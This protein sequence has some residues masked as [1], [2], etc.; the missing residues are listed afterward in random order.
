MVT[1]G[2]VTGELLRE[3]RCAAGIGLRRMAAQTHYTPSYL[4][5]VETGR[6]PV[7]EGVL[8][9][10]RAVLA[11][12]VLDGVDVRRLG[13]TVADPSGAGAAG[14]ADLS[15]GSRWPSKSSSRCP[16]DL[17]RMTARR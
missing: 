4:S 8:E 11:D 15:V 13:A 6:R 10:Y 9:R 12:P 14:V 7:T 16:T 5:L 2:T 1:D 17:L 3:L